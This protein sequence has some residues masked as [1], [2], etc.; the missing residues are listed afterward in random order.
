VHTYKE[1]AKLAAICARNACSA[2][3]KAVAAELWRMAKEHQAEAAR[4]GGKM[5]DIGDPPL[6]LKD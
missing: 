3:T 1:A 2:S 4:M 6:W 5:P